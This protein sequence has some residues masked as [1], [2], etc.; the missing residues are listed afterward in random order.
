VGVFSEHSVLTCHGLTLK[1]LVVCTVSRDLAK[2]LS[3]TASCKLMLMQKVTT[4]W[5]LNKI[6]KCMH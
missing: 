2:M 4:N 3:V 6:I 5:K 1:L